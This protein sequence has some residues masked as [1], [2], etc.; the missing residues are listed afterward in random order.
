M[1]NRSSL[2]V[3]A[4][5]LG[6][7]FAAVRIEVENGETKGQWQPATNN[8][9]RCNPGSRATGYQIQVDK[10]FVNRDQQGMTGIIIFCD[11]GSV[12][13]ATVDGA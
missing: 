8:Y 6:V 5:V 1:I 7:V 10:G 9:Y 12:G 4:A 13:N 2:L 3:L 11:D